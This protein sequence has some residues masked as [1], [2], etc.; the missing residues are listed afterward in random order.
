M[1][2]AMGFGGYASAATAAATDSGVTV[3]EDVIVTARRT[4]ERLQS[5]PV[6]VTAMTQS[7]LDKKAI[8]NFQDL[9]YTVP[10][11]SFSQTVTRDSN[12]ISLRGQTTAYGSTFNAVETLFADVP[13]YGGAGGGGANAP[14]YD[15]Q[16]VQVL[17]GPQGVAFGRN[18]TGG[19]VLLTPQR[20]KYVFEGYIKGMVGNFQAHTVE[21]VLNVP[22]IDGKLAVRGS[23]HIERRDGWTKNL[24]TGTDLDD[25]HLDAGRLSI[26]FEPTEA[27]ENQTVITYQKQDQ[28]GTSNHLLAFNPTGQVASLY[29]AFYRGPYNVN[30]DVA[31]AIAL[32]RDSLRSEFDG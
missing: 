27:I 28:T 16:S 14:L 11:L 29:A 1:A 31:T 26:L 30:Q 17:K 4:E 13:V 18:S 19:A 8:T 25:K 32:G 20:P 3:L 10:S 15:M 9:Q 6:A 2:M 21:G 22:I 5:V 23:V 7:N 24:L 12:R